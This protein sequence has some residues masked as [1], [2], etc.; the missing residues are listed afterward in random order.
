MKITEINTKVI[1]L[2]F[3]EPIVVAFGVIR[4]I[5]T[6]IVEIKTD[7]DFIGYGEAAPF[8]PVTG[9]TVETVKTVIGIF[10]KKL[11]G[12]DPLRISLMHRIMDSVTVGHS[13]AKAAIDIALHDIFAKSLRVP[14]YVALGGEGNSY[15]TD[16]TISIGTVDE[17][18][19]EVKSCMARGF[20][21]VKLKAGLDSDK[22]VR[23]LKAVRET[24]GEDL[25]IRMDAN[26]GWNSSEA[27]KALKAM[28][29]YGLD[30]IEQP[31]PYWDLPGLRKIR[32]KTII[33]L[34]ADESLHDEKD[35]IKLINADAVDLFNIK[36]MKSKGLY[37]AG[38][39]NTIAEA[40]GIQCMIGCMGES[41][42]AITAGAHFAAAH[43]NL[44]RVDLDILF[45]IKKCDGITGGVVYDGGKATLP[46][47]SGLG[48][49][50]QFNE[51]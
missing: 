6:L 21:M 44:T 8:A 27:V 22:D 34:M 17:M 3:L 9:E 28:E 42:I 2:D 16:R 48:I 26:Q 45:A 39:I 24:C 29:P 51:L 49:E 20:T 30:L 7:S 4:S 38:K 43:R 41:P 1:E 46:R 25:I 50:V 13:S 5:D 10:K 35:A 36:L 47:S 37:G 40:A 15:E 31:I 32:E 14:L 11:I 18:V 23:V 19:E 33:P 12:E